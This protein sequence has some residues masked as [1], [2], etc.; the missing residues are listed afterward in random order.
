M[1]L[2]SG[3]TIKFVPKNKREAMEVVSLLEGIGI[4]FVKGLKYK[5]LKKWSKTMDEGEGQWT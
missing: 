2:N 1:R 4:D 3:K 5:E